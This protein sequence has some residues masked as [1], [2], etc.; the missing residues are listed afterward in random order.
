MY[1]YAKKYDEHKK[2]LK[3]QYKERDTE[4]LDFNPKL[5]KKSMQLA[6]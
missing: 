1:G 4:E 6:E 5:N 3:D 2:Q